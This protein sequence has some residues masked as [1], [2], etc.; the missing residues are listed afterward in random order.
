MKSRNQS[1]FISAILLFSLVAMIFYAIQSGALNNEPLTINEL[2]AQ[3]NAGEVKKIEVKDNDLYVTYRN[4]LTQERKSAKDP[5]SGL[6]EQLIDLG[7]STDKLS[8]PENLKIQIVLG[9]IWDSI[10]VLLINIV[11]FIRKSSSPF[12]FV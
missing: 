1:F 7:V 12:A 9:G 10:G 5:Q 11:P 2:A 8:D 6:V 3:I 4:P